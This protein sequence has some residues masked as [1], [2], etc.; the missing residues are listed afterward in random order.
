MRNQSIKLKRLYCYAIFTTLFLGNIAHIHA[1]SFAVCPDD[2]TVLVTPGE[3]TGTANWTV[4]PPLDNPDATVMCTHESGDTFP[5]G[6]TTVSCMSVNSAGEDVNCQFNVIV[7]ECLA[8]ETVEKDVTLIV[9]SDLPVGVDDTEDFEGV[10]YLFTDPATPINATIV[11]ISIDIYF[12]VQY[13]SCESDIE[14]RLSDPAGN[15]VYQ[16]I[17]FTTCF[18]S[19]NNPFPGELYIATIPIPSAMT[20]GNIANWVA[21]FRDTDDQNPGE[22]EYTV[23]FGKLTYETKYV[24]GGT[25]DN[26][27]NPLIFNCPE[28][29]NQAAN[30]DCGAVVSIPEPVFGVDFT[31]CVNTTAVNSYT[32]GPDASGFYPIGTTMVTWTFTDQEGNKSTCEQSITITGGDSVTFECPENVTAATNIGECTATATWNT[33][34]FADCLGGG[35]VSGTHDSGD[36]FPIGTTIVTYTAT[37]SDG[38]ES[39]CSF[40][41]IVEECDSPPPVTTSIAAP[42]DDDFFIGENDTENFA[43]NPTLIFTDPGTSADAVLTNIILQFYFRILG[44]SCESDIEIRLTDPA[45]NVT[46]FDNVYTTCDGEGPLYFIELNVPSGMTTG[47]AANWIAEFRDTND[48]NPNEAEYSV[49]WGSLSYDTVVSGGGCA[50]PIII[51]CPENITVTSDGTGS[52]FVTVPEPVFGVDFTD[53]MSATITNDYNDTSNASDTYPSGTT[54]VLWT[55]TDAAGNIATCLQTITVD[56]GTEVPEFVC[57]DDISVTTTPNMC[58]GVA[59]WNLPAFADNYPNGSITNSTHNPGDTFPLG[60]TTVT[61]TANDGQGNTVTCSFEVRVEDM[62][63]PSVTCPTDIIVETAPGMCAAEVT[64]DAPQFTDNCSA[65]IAG[66]SHNSGDIFP[67]GT[68]TI[69]YNIVDETGNTAVCS[70]EVTVAECVSPPPVTTSISTPDDDDFFIGENDTQNFADN[71]TLIFT[72]PGTP[73]NAVLTNIKLELYFRVFGNSCENDIEV[74]LMDPVGNT[75]VFTP[76]TTCNGEGP[77]YFIEL[78]VPSAAT[79]GTT[80]DWVV[81]F[82][83]TNDQNQGETEYSVRW[84]SLSYD[85]LVSSGGC[86]D[87]IIVNCPEDVTAV[88]NMGDCTAFVTIPEPQFGVDFTDCVN[89]T[90]TNSY[91][92]TSNASDTYPPGATTIIWTATDAQGNIATCAQTITVQDTETL[93][94]TCPANITVETEPGMCTATATWNEPLLSNNC[95]GSSTGGGGMNA[96]HDSG[97]EF[98]IGTTTVTYTVMDMQDNEI[99][100]SFDILVKECASPP[101]VTTSLATPDD[102]DIFVGE[103]DTENFADNPTLIFIDPATPANAILTNIKLELYFR[104]FGNSCE[105][106]IEVRLMDPVGNTNIFTPFTT[107]NGEGP[108]Y[109]IELNV[110]SAATTGTAA[111]WIAEFR[112]TNDQNGGESEYSVRWG[113]LSYDTEVSGGGCADPTIVNCPQSISVPPGADGCSAVIDIPEPQFGV[114]FTDCSMATMTNSFNATSNA[115]GTY[116]IGTTTVIW[117]ATD[118]EG[119]FATCVQIITVEDTEAPQVICPQNIVLETMPGMCS[120]VADWETPQFTD[121]CGASVT[122]VSHESGDEFPIGTTIVS[123]NIADDAGNTAVCSFEVIVEECASPPPVTTSLATPDDEDIFIG[124]NDTENFA[125]NPTLIFTDPATP[126]NA[127][128]TNIKLELYFR[129]FGNSCENDIEVRLTDPVGNMNTFTPFITCNG[130]GPL[131]FIELFVPSAATTGAIADWVAEFRDTN[132]QNPS[133]SEYSVRWGRL[134]YETITSGGGCSDPIIVNCPENITLGADDCGSFV[135]IPEPQFG[136]DFIDCTGATIRNN[137]TG[138]SNASGNYPPGITNILWTATDTEGNIA[139]CIQ[140]ITVT[141][142]GGQALEL[143]C[144]DDIIVEADNHCEAQ[145][146]WTPPLGNDNCGLNITGTAGPGD[147]FSLGTTTVTYTA[148]DSIG[149]T[150]ACSFEVIVEDNTAPVALCPPNITIDS[151]DGICGAS[152]TQIVVPFY[153]DNCGIASVQNTS[154]TTSDVLPIGITT[155]SYTLVDG[156]GNTKVCNYDVTVADTEAPTILNCPEDVSVIAAPGECETILTVPVPIFGED[157]TDCAEGAIMT[158]DYNGTA[159]ASG[160][161]PVGTTIVVWTATD[162]NGNSATCEQN[163]TVEEQNLTTDQLL[164]TDKDVF[165]GAYADNADFH[166]SDSILINDPGV[167][168]NAVVNS[169]VLDFFFSPEGN[170]CE[171]DVELE[172]TDPAGSVYPI[173]AAPTNTCNGTDAIFQFILP[174]A[175]VPTS[176]GVWKLRFRDTE[177]QN[178]VSAGSPGYA[179]PPGT[180][181]SIRFGRI[182]Y[183][184]TIDPDCDMMLVNEQNNES[185]QP[186]TSTPQQLNNSTTHQLT[187][188]LKL[189]PVPAKDQLNIEYFSDENENI[190]IEL[191]HVN[192]AVIYSEMK[193]TWEGKNILQIGLHDLPEG[194]YYIKL[195]DNKGYIQAKPFTKM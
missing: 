34:A 97:G 190:F 71:P 56:G 93:I 54:I 92:S 160:V 65:S 138:T 145:A 140:T 110:P 159:N 161:Y 29:I 73:A 181:Y 46:I 10:T 89:A 134:S 43:D 38:N 148:T 192:G 153:G 5:I 195:T 53:C 169:V 28:D 142:G 100:C 44:N 9:D 70:F 113:R 162:M 111:N 149:N 20:T 175:D 121:N 101:P 136:V 104:V 64:W 141:G 6:T 37:D 85:T 81:E 30:I 130:E 132:D 112:D 14:V 62:Q 107:C 7:N 78:N 16:G 135:E 41:V 168:N 125:D 22:V 123:Y 75:N 187:T 1:E 95:S 120:V 128:L 143:T 156:S 150:T 144:P 146:F 52:T 98:P 174:V 103:N 118:T 193:N 131:Y 4:L 96:T 158:N 17:P 45:G 39:T 74:R 18:G 116:P 50:D 42:D 172:V 8:G 32:G 13:A 57:P 88:P 11:N 133:E 173:F 35:T 40:E 183:N 48:Q 33:P 66:V 69:T 151:Q 179:V 186:I 170:S 36:E 77:L 119:N 58:N 26:C 27:G 21:E 12:R 87:P 129:V 49:R 55:A 72:D 180:E 139:T 99:T 61:Y 155:V 80:A 23:R 182:T 194:L 3:C 105:N 82:R 166:Q 184:V 94:L 176:G 154:H 188:P 171:R 124:E 91:N 127:V 114:D 63:G 122:N 126:A 137:Y 152:L 15:V 24:I 19:G 84:G 31:D 90:I 76:F 86:A 108:L 68:T 102:D 157:Y 185:Q 25:G 178:P 177:D 191:I 51:N 79:T 2:I 167:P 189:F 117:T 47:T 164:V 106:D 163:I 60:T 165:V 59:T 67:I 147:V 115:S 109:F 83:D